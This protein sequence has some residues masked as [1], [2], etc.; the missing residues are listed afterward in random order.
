VPAMCSLDH[1]T[2]TGKTAQHRMDSKFLKSI[3]LK[4]ST[5]CFWV[6]HTAPRM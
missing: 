2:D 5:T 3:H 4:S 1:F 6:A